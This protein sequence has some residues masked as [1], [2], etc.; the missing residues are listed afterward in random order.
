MSN[1]IDNSRPN[2]LPGYGS[3]TRESFPTNPN[4]SI[5][6]PWCDITALECRLNP[7]RVSGWK[8]RNRL[9]DITLTHTA[10]DELLAADGSVLFSDADFS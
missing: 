3:L 2:F 4:E 1:S 9:G 5:R 7:D 8:V 10:L 6:L